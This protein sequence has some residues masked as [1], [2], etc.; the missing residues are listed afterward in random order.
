MISGSCLALQPSFQRSKESF[1]VYPFPLCDVF[2]SS[3]TPFC[4]VNTITVQPLDSTGITLRHHYYGPLRLPSP[5]TN[6]VMVF[7]TSFQVLDLRQLDAERI[8]QIPL[9]FF[10]CALSPITPTVSICA[11]VYFFHINSR[12]HHFRKVGRRLFRVTRPKRVHF[13]RA[14]IFVVRKNHLPSHRN[15]SPIPQC[16]ACFVTSTRQR[17]TNWCINNYQF[18]FHAIE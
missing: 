6:R 13:I 16:F 3:G 4:S 14:H 8:S 17:A 15:I 1:R 18:Q 9:L 7:P 5:R 2:R 10:R 12:L 11:Y